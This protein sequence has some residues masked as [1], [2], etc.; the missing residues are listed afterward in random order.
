M[1]EWIYTHYIPIPDE[2][3]WRKERLTYLWNWQESSKETSKYFKGFFLM[4]RC[5]LGNTQKKSTYTHT[6]S[7]MFINSLHFKDLRA[8]CCEIRW[9]GA[10]LSSI[11]TWKMD[12]KLFC[13]YCLD[14]QFI[15]KSYYCSHLTKYYEVKQF[16]KIYT[17]KWKIITKLSR[18]PSR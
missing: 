13:I 1:P 4:P 12:S 6:L 15:S 16:S 17:F 8:I 2:Q 18:S 14:R 7:R 5:E 3:K 9:K 10:R 11:A